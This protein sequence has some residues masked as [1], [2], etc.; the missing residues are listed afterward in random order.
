MNEMIPIA[1][2]DQTQE[3]YDALGEALSRFPGT[4]YSVTRTLRE[5]GTLVV[6]CLT[7]LDGVG[8]WLPVIEPA[9]VDETVTAVVDRVAATVRHYA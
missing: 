2:N 6:T 1:A 9:T 7:T 5:D 4:K 8:D 3:A